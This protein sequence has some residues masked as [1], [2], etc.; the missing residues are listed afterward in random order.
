MDGTLPPSG[1]VQERIAHERAFGAERAVQQ[2][3]ERLDL[4][5]HRHGILRQPVALQQQPL[6]GLQPAAGVRHHALSG[7]YQSRECAGHQ[8]GAD[9][10]RE[11]RRGV[12]ARG[13]QVRATVHDSRHAAHARPF[14]AALLRQLPGH[15]ASVEQA[16][17]RC[18]RQRQREQ[19]RVADGTVGTVARPGDRG[20]H[21]HDWQ[22]CEL[23]GRDVLLLLG[24]LPVRGRQL[25]APD[26]PASGQQQPDG[27]LPRRDHRHG[28]RY[29]Q[30]S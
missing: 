5:G 2:G 27:G 4:P 13:A 12:H 21:G 10:V 19:P 30:V 20:G 8:V 9:V 6:G 25:L 24:H 16:L 15:A 3:V 14:R 18:E 28:G 7:Q 26:D 1:G 22:R 17:Q 23:G 29:C 11:R